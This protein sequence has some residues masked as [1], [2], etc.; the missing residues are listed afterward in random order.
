LRPGEAYQF[1]WSREVVVLN[2]V[3]VIVK[4]ARP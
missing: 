2:G 1:G 3:T 4:A